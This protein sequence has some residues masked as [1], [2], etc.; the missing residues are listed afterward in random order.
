MIPS[1]LTHL[2]GLEVNVLVLHWLLL[3]G[4]WHTHWW[5]LTL[6]RCQRPGLS[7]HLCSL[8][9]FLTS[10]LYHYFPCHSPLDSAST[11]LMS[12]MQLISYQDQSGRSRCT[13][14]VSIIQVFLYF[15]VDYIDKCICPFHEKSGELGNKRQLYNGTCIMLVNRHEI[16]SY[17]YK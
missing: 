7:F 2:T 12:L 6:S 17:R 9:I 5:Y 10:H 3:S 8:L 4:M 1:D 11:N 13:H 16:W 14:R 15:H